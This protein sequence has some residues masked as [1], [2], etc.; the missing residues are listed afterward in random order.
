[1]PLAFSPGTG[2]RR[3]LTSAPPS[4]VTRS[5]FA[6][7]PAERLRTR[8]RKEA[9]PPTLAEQHEMSRPL[10]RTAVRGHAHLL[11]GVRAAQAVPQ[12][13]IEL[14]VWLN[15]TCAR[16]CTEPTAFPPAGSRQSASRIRS[17]EGS[18]ATRPLLRR[19]HPD[20]HHP[21]RT[22]HP[23]VAVPGPTS[24]SCTAY[25]TR[26]P[27][28]RGGLVAHGRRAVPVVCYDANPLPLFVP[29]VPVSADEAP[30]QPRTGSTSSWNSLGSGDPT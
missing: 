14:G 27:G 19:T 26:G 4:A 12:R 5:R 30:G 8:D 10:G 1:M 24:D 28:A 6:E 7:P 21:P 13:S 3:P 15:C 23:S 9:L 16:R 18:D 2:R 25:R 29:P 11:V 17:M 20:T 22:P